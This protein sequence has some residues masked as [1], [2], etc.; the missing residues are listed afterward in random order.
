[1]PKIANEAFVELQAVYERL[2]AELEPFRRKCD[3]RGVCCDFAV[4]G[5]MLYVTGLEA[6]GM[7][8]SGVAP[9]AAQAEEGR[10]P[11]L[12][13]KLCGIRDHRALGCRMFYCDKTFE[14]DR[15]AV[16]ERYLKQIRDIEVRFGIETSYTP[17]TNVNFQEYVNE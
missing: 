10:C 12:N 1:M 3:S 15:N 9:S 13:G 11:F 6:A 5:H 8:Q 14:E 17:V 4:I 2:N 7:L 16:Y